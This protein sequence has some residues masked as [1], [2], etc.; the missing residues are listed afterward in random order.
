MDTPR[1]FTLSKWP[2]SQPRARFSMRHLTFQ[3]RPELSPFNICEEIV[4]SDLDP[5]E[6]RK[7]LDSICRTHRLRFTY[8]AISAVVEHTIIMPLIG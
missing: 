6:A 2:G 3:E 1:A 7:F 8:D 5:V 4:L